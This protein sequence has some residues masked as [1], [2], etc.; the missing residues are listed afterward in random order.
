MGSFTI[1]AVIFSGGITC[2]LSGAIVMLIGEY[3]HN[4]LGRIVGLVYAISG[5]VAA[6]L[7]SIWAKITE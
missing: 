3:T 4:N 5:L 6:L 2:W 7:A 1:S